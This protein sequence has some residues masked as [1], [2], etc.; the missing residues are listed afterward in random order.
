MRLQEHQ[1]RNSTLHRRVVSAYNAG[2][3]KLV[4]RLVAAHLYVASH[5]L[6]NVHHRYATL[7]GIH[8]QLPNPWLLRSVAAAE[9]AHN[10]T[11]KL[12][13][14]KH[15]AH[16][17]LLDA[18][19]ERENHNVRVHGKVRNHRTCVVG[20]KD[21][22]G[23]KL[24]LDA[25]LAQMRIVEGVESVKSVG[26]LLGASVATQQSAAKEDAH[27]RHHRMAVVVVSRSQLNTRHKVLLAVGTQLTDRQLRAGKD[28]RL[29]QVLEHKRQCTCRVSHSVGAMQNHEA[30]VT[31]VSVGNDAHNL[32]PASKRNVR[33]VDWRRK[34]VSVYVRLKVGKFGK[35]GNEVLEVEGFE[36]TGLWVASHTNSTAGINQQHFVVALVGIVDV[37]LWY[38]VI[39]GAK[40]I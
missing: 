24:K 7:R 2:I 29:G 31:V 18:R 3:L 15:M 21:K 6:R 17:V 26:T 28:N 13:S 4:A 35:I 14:L 39:Y 38:I 10:D 23:V 8:K 36:S 1:L 16:N 19:E 37:H 30:V 34:L 25:C 11:S 40:L 9:R 27:L 32:S 20:L 5:T 12:G 22:V 33:R